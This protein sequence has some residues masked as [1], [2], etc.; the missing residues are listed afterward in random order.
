MLSYDRWSSRAAAHEHRADAL[1]AAYRARRARG[2][3]HP[4]EDF[5]HTYYRYSPARLRRWHPGPGVVLEGA[6]GMPRATWRF[7]RSVGG[8]VQLDVRAFLAARGT[9]TAFV[10]DLLGA[11]HDRPA[12][13]GCYALHEWA[14]VYRLGPRE[15]RHASLP[16]R[17]GH[18]ATDAVVE[19]HPIRCSHYDAFRFFTEPAR[20]RNA[21][22]PTRESQAALEQPGCLHAGMD[23]Y[24]W[25]FK[26]APA[27]PSEL[28]AD[29]FVLAR[30]LRE[31]DM[32]A[33]PYDVRLL[34]LEPVA[35]ETPEGKAEFV[36]AQRELSG[37]A[38]VL[39]LRLLG[40]IAAVEDAAAG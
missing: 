35:V 25:A 29:A 38:N 23:V 17:L 10:R 33:S 34:G 4:G 16:L 30:Q 6:A 22:R 8:A 26:L 24:K 39:R 1:T 31:L 12:Q 20:P 40:A 5:L 11:T 15:V 18:A 27:I 13:L 7:Y 37:R 3:M 14:M 19:A 21:L 32:R 2:E 28:V 36:A 9:T